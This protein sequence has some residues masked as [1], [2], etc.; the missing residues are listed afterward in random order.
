VERAACVVSNFSG[1]FHAGSRD[2][3]VD[4]LTRQISGQ[5]RWMDNMRALAALAPR[6]VVEVGP[7][8]PLRGFFATL[9]VR[10]D[11]ISSIASARQV[12]ER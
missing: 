10:V 11:A 9:R 4:A 8:T 12:F 5:V 7:T 1:G 2:L 6:R 3:L